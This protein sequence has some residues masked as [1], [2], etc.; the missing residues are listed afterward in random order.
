MRA[1]ANPGGVRPGL[2]VCLAGAV[3]WGAPLSASCWVPTADSARDFDLV[4]AGTVTANELH[5]ETLPPDLLRSPRERRREDQWVTIRVE[6][7]FRGADRESVQIIARGV[8]CPVGT[9]ACMDSGNPPAQLPVGGRVLVFSRSE[10]GRFFVS[11]CTTWPASGHRELI[12]E[13]RGRR[14]RR[15]TG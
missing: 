1:R 5:T 10:S 13:L 3:F 2:A 11:G 4:F 6:E 9:F 12:E 7:V 15:T 14:R 8:P